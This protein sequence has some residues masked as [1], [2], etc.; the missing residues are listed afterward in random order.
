MS[1]ILLKGIAPALITPFDKDGNIL[2]ESI[3][4]NIADK[5]IFTQLYFFCAKIVNLIDNWQLI[6]DFDADQD[7]YELWIENHWPKGYI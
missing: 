3:K 4:K 6:I 7:N 2:T 1:N 5:S